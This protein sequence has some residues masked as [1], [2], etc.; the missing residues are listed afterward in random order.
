MLS[1]V[2]AGWERHLG[3]VGAKTGMRHLCLILDHIHTPS[4][5]VSVH[6]SQNFGKKLL[7]KIY[8]D[9]KQSLQLESTQKLTAAAPS[10]PELT[11]PRC[12]PCARGWYR[13]NL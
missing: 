5:Y 3:R 6:M 1:T 4:A 13:Q 9:E 7:E 2:S 11:V 10:S 12:V 8:F